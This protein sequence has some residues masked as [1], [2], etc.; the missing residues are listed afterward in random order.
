MCALAAFA[1]N[2]LANIDP[3]ATNVTNNS[4]Q[5]PSDIQ[6]PIF[7]NDAAW[8]FKRGSGAFTP[9]T[10]AIALKENDE[11]KVEFTATD[12]TNCFFNENPHVNIGEG[13]GTG[14]VSSSTEQIGSTNTYNLS[15]TYTIGSSDEGAITFDFILSDGRVEAN[16]SVDGEAP[17]YTVTADNTVPAITLGSLAEWFYETTVQGEGEMS[18][19]VLS[20]TPI[21]N[22]VTLGPGRIK[23]FVSVTELNGPV[24]LKSNTAVVKIGGTTMNITE[25]GDGVTIEEIPSGS[26]IYYV[27]MI[28]TIPDSG[29]GVLSFEFTL[30]DDAGN[31]LIINT[32]NGQQWPVHEVTIDTAQP[33][34]VSATVNAAGDAITIEYSEDLDGDT[35]TSNGNV[36]WTLSNLNSDG[37]TLTLGSLSQNGNTLEKFTFALNGGTFY[38]GDE[39]SATNPNGINIYT[40]VNGPNIEDLAGNNP[41]AISNSNYNITN[42]ST[43]VLET[44]GEV[45]GD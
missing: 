6:P 18:D 16:T 7:N 41:V 20:W 30:K 36:G 38:A 39:I 33:T 15:I 19:P 43:Q 1:G 26:G 42:N 24:T 10:E 4:S 31:E 9:L 8:E 12:D 25:S 29:N 13:N 45:G 34:F 21:Y 28:Y 14:S 27:H 40:E 2:L 35:V 37:D 17:L 11:L 44:E 32:V 23:C 3:V 22:A 5:I